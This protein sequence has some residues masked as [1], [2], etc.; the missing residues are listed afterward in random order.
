MKGV[1]SHVGSAS[2]EG[3]DHYQIVPAAMAVGVDHGCR[4]FE[5]DFLKVCAAHQPWSQDSPG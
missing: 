2:Y 4:G 5:F 3:G 1:G